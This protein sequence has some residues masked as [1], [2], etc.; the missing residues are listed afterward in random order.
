MMSEPDDAPHNIADAPPNNWVDLYV[1]ARLQPYFR[2]SRLDRPIGTWLLLW[3][4]LWSLT[5]AT[6]ARGE[7]IPHLLYMALFI[8]GAF[9]MR[10]AGC[11]YNDIVD[12]DID[13]KV[14]R[15]AGRPLPAGDVKLEQAIGWMAAQCLVGLVILLT[16]NGPT[17]WLGG[18]I[19]WVDRLLPVHEAH[20]LLAASLARTYL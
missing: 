10:G 9:V 11:T 17:I 7:A 4:C 13:A 19:S 14:S 20:Y 12:R 1:P 5:L 18:S 8:I 3:P 15:T 16:F 6:S 2:L